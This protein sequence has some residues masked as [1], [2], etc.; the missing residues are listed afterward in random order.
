M[1]K[2]VEHVKT[3]R[4]IVHAHL[5]KH[6]KKYV[7]GVLS[8]ALLIKII[9]A[10]IAWLATWH[11]NY[12]FADA[13]VTPEAWELWC[14]TDTEWECNSDFWTYDVEISEDAKTITFS[15]IELQYPND[16]KPRPDPHAGYYW[17]KIIAPEADTEHN[18]TIKIG[19]HDY[20]M[21]DENKEWVTENGR[22]FLYYWPHVTA[23]EAKTALEDNEWII[24][25][26]VPATL[27]EVETILTIN[28]D[29]NNLTY[30][31][32]TDGDVD[33]KVVDWVVVIFNW[34]EVESEWSTETWYTIT[35]TDGVEDEE[36]F[37]DQ[38]TTWLSIWDDI[39]GFNWTPTRTWYTF[40]GWNPEV[41]G[42]VSWNQ[43]Y[44]AQWNINDDWDN[45]SWWDTWSWGETG[46]S[47][48][49][50]SICSHNS[51]IITA[52][53]SWVYLQSENVRLTWTLSGSACSG[54][55]FAIKLYNGN[56]SGS[57]TLLWTVSA[58]SGEFSNLEDFNISGLVETN[59]AIYLVE[60]GEIIE[61]VKEGP[62]FFI[63]NI[64]PEII[65]STYA[66]NP[67]R[68]TTY[69]LND[70]V[71]VS[72]TGSEE[73]TGITV[74]VL[75]RNAT[76]VSRSWLKYNYTIQLSSGNNTWQFG[77][78]ISFS[79]LAGNTWYYEYFNSWLTLDTTKPEL[80]WLQ[81]RRI[82]DKTWFVSF[83]TT[84][85]SNITFKYI[86]SWWK[87]TETLTAQNTTGMRSNLV[88][89]RTDRTGYVYKY[90]ITLEDLLWNKN[91]YAGTF[92]LSG[93]SL[94]YTLVTANWDSISNWTTT[95]ILS[96][97]SDEIN[98]FSW[99]KNSLNMKYKSMQYTV[100]NRFWFKPE[101]PTFDD[102]SVQDTAELLV[103]LLA[104]TGWLSKSSITWLTQAKVNS[105]QEDLNNYLVII[106]IKR[107][108]DVCNAHLSLLP[109]LYMS[110]FMKTLKSYKLI[111]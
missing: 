44:T 104:G 58:N 19:S 11:F 14:W 4:K 94:W 84:K 106:K 90:V 38:I 29:V 53:T 36:I 107:D 47:W 27:S 28:I 105:F 33:F 68:T 93:D 86:L 77:Y 25:I 50:N 45:G 108:P 72:F 42:N 61:S 6:H 73:L 87:A 1:K 76:F 69:G 39:P 70:R 91:Y 82:S 22:Y 30:L 7:F 97:L 66:F 18:S 64:K 49:E 74:N 26:T 56:D 48:W 81:F 102:S 95:N 89:A 78:N 71:N 55:I 17:V 2:L 59:F 85:P 80:S 41:T 3:H 9:P 46:G 16:D 92:Q 51:I 31:S 54:K 10:F 43:T 32:G 62:T 83:T 75:W 40:S 79:D 96:T 8:A 88:K 109:S 12:L 65:D 21:N 23:D 110:K 13:S 100:Q 111:K 20:V 35:Y 60:D 5:K 99:C 98:A 24:R 52:P 15:N 103:T 63:D 57:Y 101:V 34:E 37:A 67:A